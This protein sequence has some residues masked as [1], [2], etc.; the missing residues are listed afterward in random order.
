MRRFALALLSTTV[1][2]GGFAQVASAADLPRGAPAYKAPMAEPY[3]NWSGFY[4]GGSLGGRWS[5]ADWATTRALAPIGGTSPASY[6]SSSFRGG[7]Y[8]GVNFQ[9]S[10]MIVA[11]IEADI[12]WAKNESTRTGIPGLTVNSDSTT[13]RQHWDSSVV[14]RLG[15][16]VTPATL[17]YAVGGASW[18][19][20]ESNTTCSIA[21]GYCLAARNQT[22]DTTRAGWTVGAGL[23]T[24]LMGN[25]LARVE[26]RY[27]DYGKID[28]TF[29]AGTADTITV[30]EDLRTH[31]AK[32]GL[33]Y[34]FG[35]GPL[36]AKY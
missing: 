29:F 34:K 2:A 5:D 27:A 9:L 35:G 18:I 12:G 19:N 32:V 24:M 21:G 14:G 11:G 15:V 6:D 30:S 31:T 1:L 10:P 20:V 33:A 28:N 13:L 16:L 25:W 36:Y 22:N 8:G 17:L 3:S 4:L 23:E 7:I 26:Y